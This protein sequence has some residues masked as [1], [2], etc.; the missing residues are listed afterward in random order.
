MAK[1]TKELAETML[2]EVDWEK[3]FYCNDGK[4]LKSLPELEVAL[5]EMSDD[6]FSYHSNEVKTDFGNWVRDVIGD[7]KL[8][9]DLTK[10]SNRTQAQKN[11]AARIAWLRNKTVKNN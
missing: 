10:S 5:K 4:Y 1:I 3:R 8:S 9:R 7:E 2:G 11:V 6:T